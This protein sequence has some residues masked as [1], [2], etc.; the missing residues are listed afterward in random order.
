[1]R[2]PLPALVIGLAA[3]LASAP[4]R[5]QEP[6]QPEQPRFETT[7]EVVLVDVTVASSNGEPVTGLTAKDFK[8]VVNGQPRPVH[9]VQFVTSRG[10]K[11][12]VEAPRL[13]EVSGNDGP[14]T[15]RLLLF[16]ID[17]NYLRVG[18]ARIRD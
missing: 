1:M 2:S 15:G 14:S 12:P 9:T 10:M 6:P 4:A 18:A 13:A 3:L 17:E 16:V 7:A 8:L 11:A 5:A